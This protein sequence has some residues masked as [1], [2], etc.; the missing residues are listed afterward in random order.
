VPLGVIT[1]FVSLTTGSFTTTTTGK[2]THPLLFFTLTLYEPGTTPLNTPVVFKYVE[3]SILYVKPVPTGEL[4]LIPPVFSGHIGFVTSTVGTDGVNGCAFTT[5]TVAEL[6]H[7][8]LFLTVTLYV[9]ATTP[10]N[11]PVLLL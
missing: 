6:I 11:T 8:A 2:L 9:P 5:A 3:P 1:N 10:L 4:T 7:P